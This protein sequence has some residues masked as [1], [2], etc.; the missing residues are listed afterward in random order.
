MLRASTFRGLPLYSTLH[1]RAAS[2]ITKQ[3]GLAGQHRTKP[4]AGR[5]TASSWSCRIPPAQAKLTSDSRPPQRRSSKAALPPGYQVSR[6]PRYSL[7]P[8]SVCTFPPIKL[9]CRQQ[10]QPPVSHRAIPAPELSALRLQDHYGFL[11][12]YF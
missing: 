4:R 12:S 9:L 1:P 10:K 3:H 11:N 7:S 6:I 2:S 5:G 8:A